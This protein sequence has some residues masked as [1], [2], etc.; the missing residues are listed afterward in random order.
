MFTS[1]ILADM[2][3]FQVFYMFVFETRTY[4]SRIMAEHKLTFSFQLCL[5][6]MENYGNPFPSQY[7]D[8]IIESLKLPSEHMEMNRKHGTVEKLLF[9]FLLHTFHNS[10]LDDQCSVRQSRNTD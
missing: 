9:L 2:M 6:V 7:L 4:F 8:L 5:K 1:N 3:H 10:R